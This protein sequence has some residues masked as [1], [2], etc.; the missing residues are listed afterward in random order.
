[1]SP[2]RLVQVDGPLRFT[3]EPG[4]TLVLGRSAGC[5]L[6]VASPAVSRRHAELRIDGDGLLVRDLETANGTTLNGVAVSAPAAARVDDLLGFGGSVFRVSTAPARSLAE[7]DLPGG[8]TLRS[9]ARLPATMGRDRPARA[10]ERLL[11]VAAG[12]SGDPALERVLEE[13]TELCFDQVDADRAV[14]LLSDPGTGQLTPVTARSRQGEAMPRVPRRIAERAVADRAPVIM[15]AGSDD[16]A[17][18][19]GSVRAQAVRSALCVPLLADGQVLGALYADTITRPTPFGD[20]EA[21]TFAA[22]A[23]LAAVTIARVRFAQEARRERERRERLERFFAPPVAAA[24]AARDAADPLGGAR[25]EVAV[26]F[27]DIRGFSGIAARL[28]PEDT[29]ALLSDYFAVMVDVV[30]EHGG[31]LDK[32]VGDGVMAVWGAPLPDPEAPD[33]AWDAARM[34]LRE[35]ATLNARRRA[36]GRPPIEAGIGLAVGE[37][38]AGNIGSGRRLEYTVVGD[39]VNLA[40]RLSAAAGPG[41]ILLADAAAARLSDP[42]AA[43]PE[44]AE[45]RGLGDV[46]VRRVV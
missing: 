28:T 18:R 29:A 37:V 39:A 25:R 23:G 6:L 30:F 31:T 8:T 22:F 19:G 35:L 40:A 4:R 3:I 33:R 2:L 5:D 21:T 34:M 11:A 24:I 15:D 42:P 46:L 41:E 14:L 9:L 17:L 20:D 36:A 38:F 45:V 12:L 44:R 1:M 26:V 32:F 43:D 7:D 27:S 16:P 10:L 13:I